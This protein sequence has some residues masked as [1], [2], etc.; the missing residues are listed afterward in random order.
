MVS[1]RLWTVFILVGAAFLLT[2]A[3]AA[4]G[5]FPGK[6]G[7]IAYGY[8]DTIYTIAPGDAGGQQLVTHPDGGGDPAW[9]PD[10]GRL[11]FASIRGGEQDIYV[12]DADGTN[13]RRLTSN[14]A[15]EE[16]NPSWV[17]NDTVIF[18]ADPDSGDSHVLDRRPGR[19]TDLHL[20][21]LPGRQSPGSST[22]S[23]TRRSPPAGE[24]LFTE[25]FQVPGTSSFRSAAWTA[26]GNGAATNVSGTDEAAW[27]GGW[28]PDGVEFLYTSTPPGCCDT[29]VFVDSKASSP[30][31]I[32]NSPGRSEID[33]P[34]FSPDGTMVVFGDYSTTST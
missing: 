6:N 24:L 2:A 8:L 18:R 5:T 9:S 1:A 15:I 11:A 12:I 19:R 25:N 17:D 3:P 29:D 21:V 16:E 30:V 31:N 23:P 14:D 32:T 22:T 7:K 34:K 33:E 13:E 28:S 26:S 10:G 4:A 20:R 27:A